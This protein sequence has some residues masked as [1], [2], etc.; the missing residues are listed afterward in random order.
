MRKAFLAILAIRI[1]RIKPARALHAFVIF[2]HLS[3]CAISE[4][5]RYLQIYRKV[6]LEYITL[7]GLSRN[8]FNCALGKSIREKGYIVCLV[9]LRYQLESAE[10]IYPSKRILLVV[11]I[12]Y[13]IR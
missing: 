11:A 4:Y 6:S 13:D 5:Q 3:H 2:Q 9:R 8:K 12:Y 1:E 10:L 7:E